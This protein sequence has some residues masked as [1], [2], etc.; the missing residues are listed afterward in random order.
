MPAADFSPA[1]FRR[2]LLFFI[3]L[4][5]Q[6]QGNEPIEYVCTLPVSPFS[7]EFRSG[8]EAVASPHRMVRVAL[9]PL[10]WNARGTAA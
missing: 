10:V 9:H 1:I 4:S 7:R 2:L 6:A 8:N 3:P 5:A